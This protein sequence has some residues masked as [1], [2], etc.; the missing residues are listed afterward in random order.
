MSSPNSGD[1][2][3]WSETTPRIAR[4]PYHNDD[5]D[6]D[7]SLPSPSFPV[8]GS[9][10]ETSATFDDSMSKYPGSVSS[11]IRAHVYEDGLR[12]HKYRDGR[13][14]FPNDE[15]E[16]NRDDMK[17]AMLQTLMDGKH[18]YAPVEAALAA[19]GEALDLGTSFI[20][21]TIER[22]YF[23]FV[24]LKK[25]PRLTLLFH[26]RNGNRHLGYRK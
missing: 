19:G 25:L 4:L 17:H 13:Y 3:Y 18:F 24:L 7:L 15:T 8:P 23:F 26:N 20:L 9:S 2:G 16:Q 5:V 21:L 12:Y 14:P 10:Y 6:E 11:S 22:Q 1:T